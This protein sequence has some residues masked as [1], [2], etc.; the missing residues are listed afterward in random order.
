LWC[1]VGTAPTAMFTVLNTF[2][3][4]V[5]RK[6]LP[7][8]KFMSSLVHWVVNTVRWGEHRGGMF[9]RLFGRDANGGMCRRRWHMIAEG[10]N[11]PYVPVMAAAAV[12]GRCLEGQPPAPG[13]RAADNELELQDFAPLLAQREI[14]SMML[15]DVPED[16][17]RPVYRRVLESHYNDLAE[18]LQQLH[19]VSGSHAYRGSS[20][21]DRGSNPLA[22][23]LAS[24]MGF[25][26]AGQDVPVE[27][28]LSVKNRVETWVRRF[29]GKVFASTQEFG[30]GRYEGLVVERFGPMAFGLALVEE[31]TQ[32]H[33]L[34]RRW[35]IFG[36]AMPVMLAPRIVAFEHAARDRFNFSVNLSLP[37]IGLIVAYR[38]WL[39]PAR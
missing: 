20:R 37:L 27:V 2:A 34:M 3:T 19:D 29:N 6:L 24:I 32:L 31:D 9:V 8:M 28:E 25:P 4:L 12:I 15:A 33:L 39:V 5:Q 30:V 1:G 21:V 11:G 17:D 18:P 16:R 7:S 13:A 26:G 36:I 38:G 23:L 14:K 22:Q 35:D 10:G